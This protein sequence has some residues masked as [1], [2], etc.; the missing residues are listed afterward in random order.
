[1]PLVPSPDR[2]TPEAILTFGA[3]GSGKTEDWACIADAYRKHGNTGQFYVL[4]TEFERVLASM[5]GR[6]GWR[7]NVHIFEASDWPSL[8]VATQTISEKVAA[9]IAEQDIAPIDNDDWIVLDVA[10]PPLRWSRDFYFTQSK[11][12]D[13]R[14]FQDEGGQSSEVRADEWGKM[15]SIYLNWFN[16]NFM[17]FPGHRFICAQSKAVDVGS[18]APKANSTRGKLFSRLGQEP[19]GYKELGAQTHTVLFKQNPSADDF[20]ISTVKDKPNRE[21]LSHTPVLSREYG[22]FVVTYLQAVAGWTV[23]S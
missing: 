17:R 19:V 9:K 4:S 20:T 5:E 10:G 18:W 15:E 1:M 11:G 22:G 3:Y 7:E 21:N 2:T 8:L 16:P 6:V 14:A 12:F 23:Q 13:Y